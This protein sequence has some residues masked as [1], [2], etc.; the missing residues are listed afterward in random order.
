MHSRFYRQVRRYWSGCQQYKRNALDKGMVLF[1]DTP[2][3]HT[4]SLFARLHQMRPPGC[5]HVTLV[6]SICKLRELCIIF[7]LGGVVGLRLEAH[8]VLCK[9]YET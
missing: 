8:K 4:D 9:S 2:V 5:C 6:E 3:G 7:G 1:R